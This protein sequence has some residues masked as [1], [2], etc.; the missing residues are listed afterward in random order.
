MITLTG[1]FIYPVKSAR[2]IA[3]RE[4]TLGDRGFVNDRRFMVVDAA[5][6]MFT[7][8]D[9]PQLARLVTAIDGD[10]LRLSSDGHVVTVP[11]HPREG[12]RRMVRVW[13]DEVEAID[14]GD[15]ANELVATL[16]RRPAGLVYMPDQTHRQV[17]P[18]YAS[19]HDLVGFAD[20]YPYLLT[21]ESSLAALND[22]LPKRIGMD[23]FRPNMVI[24]GAPAYAEDGFRKVRIGRVL[25]DVLK[26][27]TR[28]V[29]INTDQVTGEREKGPLEVLS[30]TH[31]I[32]RRVVFGQNVVARDGGVVRVGDTVT[33][34]PPS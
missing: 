28:C 4:A 20:A 11:L 10:V 6:Q 19:P 2:G 34:L 24:S 7:Q 26:P 14:A 3:L 13:R 9:A 18:T 27:C 22:A 29:T 23:R 31:L 32:D 12:A 33:L 30:R 5:G 17:D 8:R 21:N 25:F 1:L 15:D 16:L